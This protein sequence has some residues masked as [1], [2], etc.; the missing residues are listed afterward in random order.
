MSFEPDEL[1]AR[2]REQRVATEAWN[3][4]SAAGDTVD[5]AIA[6]F[7]DAARSGRARDSDGEPYDPDALSDLR[8]ALQG[9]V[10]A[11]LGGMRIADVRGTELRRDDDFPGCID[12]R[13][14]AVDLH[15]REALR[16]AEIGD[17]LNGKFRRCS[18][19]IDRWTGADGLSR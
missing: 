10:S 2:R 15:G 18:R 5:E 12:V 1:G 17:D 14:E 19:G 4:A 16:E 3:E 9:H 8:W 13:E 11:E 6:E 7:L